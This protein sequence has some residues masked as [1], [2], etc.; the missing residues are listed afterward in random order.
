MGRRAVDF[1]FDVTVGS[2]GRASDVHAIGVDVPA[3]AISVVRRVF[4]CQ[5]QLWPDTVGKPQH[6][7]FH[8]APLASMP[9]VNTWKCGYEV[10]YPSGQVRADADVQVG[11]GLDEHGRVDVAWVDGASGSG[12]AEAAVDAIAHRCKFGPAFLDG[13]PIPAFFIYTFAF[14]GAR[15]KN[16]MEDFLLGR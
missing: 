11:V 9:A 3:A 14:Q 16:K 10:V 1:E 6:Y 13:R 2:D 4:R 5:H 12:F 7:R 15:P 8:V